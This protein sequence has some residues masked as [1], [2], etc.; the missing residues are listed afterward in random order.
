MK[1]EEKS[2]KLQQLKIEND[3]KKNIDEIKP[4]ENDEEQTMN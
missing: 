4:T 3:N 1:S 2:I